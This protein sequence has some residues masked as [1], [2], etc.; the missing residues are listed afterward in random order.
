MDYTYVAGKRIKLQDGNDDTERLLAEES[1]YNP[2]GSV[3]NTEGNTGDDWVTV[4][5][6]PAGWK[7]RETKSYVVGLEKRVHIKDPNGKYFSC[8][9]LALKFMIE[10]QHTEDQVEIMRSMLDFEGWK[11][12][13][14][15]PKG[16][17]L[18][19]DGRPFDRSISFL[20]S[21]ATILKGIKAAE[22]FLNADKSYSNLD[23][24]NLRSVYSE[25]T[26][27][28]RYNDF[29]W[30]EN[31]N[32]PSGW[33]ERVT[34][35][36]KHFYLAPKGKV[37]FSSGK[38]ALQYMIKEGVSEEDQA[39]MRKVMKAEGWLESKFLPE[40]WTFKSRNS[41]GT[42]VSLL[43][44]EGACFYGFHNATEY[45]KTS[46]VY[47]DHDVEGLKL[48]QEDLSGNR[49]NESS[50]FTKS[51]TLSQGWKSRQTISGKMFFLAPDGK[52]FSGQRSALQ[53]MIQEKFSD[54]V[55]AMKI[56]MKEQGWK[57]SKYLPIDWIYKETHGYGV[58]I[59][60]KE[61]TVF[62]SYKTAHDYLEF[63]VNYGEEDIL[64]FSNLA[65]ETSNT[66]RKLVSDW[67][68]SKSL[69]PGWKTKTSS[70]GNKLFMAPEGN[71]FPS[72]KMALQYMINNQFS[73]EN[74]VKIRKSMSEDGWKESEYLPTGWIYRNTR[75]TDDYGVQILS[76]EGLTFNSY[77]AAM[78]YVGS[79]KNFSQE[80]ITNLACL[81]KENL[82]T[83]KG[84]SSRFIESNDLP[85]GWRK[86][87]MGKES[88]I[89]REG[90]QFTSVR[91]A[92]QQMIFKGYSKEDLQIMKN[93]MQPFGWQRNTN[94][95]DDWLFKH[96]K[97]EKLNHTKA[98]FISSEGTFLKSYI[99]AI[100]YMKQQKTYT[101]ESV[102]NI[103]LLISE[104]AKLTRKRMVEWESRDNL[105]F[106]WKMRVTPTMGKQYFLA[107]S[108][109]QFTGGRK[110]AL[111]Y[112]IQ[113]KFSDDEIKTM[114]N[115]LAED[116]WKKSCYLPVDWLYRYER[117][118][119]RNYATGVQIISRDGVVFHSYLSACEYMK[120]CEGFNEND[121][122]KLSK[123][124]EEVSN[125]KRQ[126]HFEGKKEWQKNENL[127]HGWKIK[128]MASGKKFF[129]SPNGK[130]FA[131][132]KSAL[133]YMIKEN[134]KTED[135]VIMRKSMIDDGWKDSLHL[136]VDWLY[137]STS[138]EV[139]ILSNEGHMFDSFLKA[140]EHLEFNG[141]FIENISK[142][143][144]ELANC[145]R[146]QESRK[147]DKSHNKLLEWKA[148]ESLPIG[149]K[150]KST[151]SGK[152]L[153]L[154][155]DGYQFAG[156]RAALQ[157]MIREK[158]SES[159][160]FQ[161]RTSMAKDGWKMSDC[162]PKD[163]LYKITSMNSH[164]VDIFSSE[165]QL[166]TSYIAAKEYMKSRQTYGNN[167]LEN[168]SQ[169][170]NKINA[171]RRQ[172]QSSWEE[173]GNLPS[174][175]KLRVTPAGQKFFLSP[176]GNQFAGRKAALQHMIK[177]RFEESHIEIMRTS[178][179][180][181]GWILSSN[182]PNG[183]MY[184]TRSW[185]R[186]E[187]SSR[188]TIAFIQPDG[189][190]LEGSKR[191]WGLIKNRSL[192]PEEASRLKVFLEK[193]TWVSVK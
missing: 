181:D 45:L 60:S 90:L 151:E 11:Y 47:T 158:F 81:S 61:G 184:K 10:S 117:D 38:S 34:K 44:S 63:S 27:V 82:K 37:Q 68:E 134:F 66:N 53:Y 153:I 126:Y 187:R 6:L 17:R 99:Q 87:S 190:I 78:K 136:P 178:L 73:D 15:L 97:A 113:E 84:L 185:T 170:C 119:T 156:R 35:S 57:E 102:G 167:D 168:L 125:L 169:L 159:N 20:S 172:N 18:K 5:S 65:K 101:E 74:I 186:K 130:Q 183:W 33:R 147:D 192:P 67:I 123:L 79:S 86:G 176:E 189:Q 135:I 88:L 142:L 138:H 62:E 8:R 121:I 162:L 165:G 64:K 31:E 28:K 95:P 148:T 98:L 9:R 55:K 77:L 24:S 25:Y 132:R 193:Q 42:R 122:I 191:A 140:K 118:I 103:T 100:E 19:T 92:Y 48:L 83:K 7:L 155:P 22:S 71:R 51:D 188:M 36:R 40:G 131:G 180:E 137:K 80:D 107:P 3:G 46:I 163:W 32:L 29:T 128:V 16:W 174:G 72:R 56:L 105:P 114:R 166:F 58:R 139:K 49:R 112:M 182:L 13:T 179:T 21:D 171:F 12:D 116:G 164:D 129:L 94:L 160:I 30:N 109:K 127:P 111:Q 106:G 115:S 177:E 157:F 39:R 141:N 14:L 149:W 133:Q 146:K 96:S 54:D 145:R 69:P 4:E 76:K 91:I 1:D 175:W 85:K 23:L 161:M 50:I 52:Q 59:I 2:I 143:I 144:E 93:Y 70:V 110:S 43:S 104:M 124:H 154:S 26:N 152:T 41:N 75:D 108:G 89:S 120:S 173:K 150:I